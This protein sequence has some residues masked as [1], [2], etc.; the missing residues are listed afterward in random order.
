MAT[1]TTSA[2]PSSAAQISV[3][4]PAG[5]YCAQIYDTGSMTVSSAFTV[6]ILHP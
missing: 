6:T 3:N 2:L 1:F 5:T 4:E